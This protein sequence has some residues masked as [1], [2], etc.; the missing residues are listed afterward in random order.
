MVAS[1]ISPI[2]ES[3]GAADPN[4]GLRRFRAG[5]I[6]EVASST[7]AIP[8]VFGTRDTK[9]SAFIHVAASRSICEGSVPMMAHGQ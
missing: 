7:T 4:P 9:R 3:V 6:A 8:E 1:L 2:V 5:K